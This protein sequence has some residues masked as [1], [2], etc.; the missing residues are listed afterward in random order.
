M[1]MLLIVKQSCKL[2][3]GCVTDLQLQGVGLRFL[4]PHVIL[5]YEYDCED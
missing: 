3:I 2:L 5:H 1:V 4:Y